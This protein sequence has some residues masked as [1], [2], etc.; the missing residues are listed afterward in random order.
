MAAVF[1]HSVAHR[2][3]LLYFSS[4]FAQVHLYRWR[5]MDYSVDKSASRWV[6]TGRM[7]SG[8]ITPSQ[9]GAR[10]LCFSM[11]SLTGWLTTADPEANFRFVYLLWIS[12]ENNLNL[13]QDSACGGPYRLLI[14]RVVTR[15][16]S[17]NVLHSRIMYLAEL[18]YKKL[19]TNSKK[20]E[21]REMHKYRNRNCLFQLPGRTDTTS[22]S[23]ARKPFPSHKILVRGE[24][25]KVI[26]SASNHNLYV[27]MNKDTT[28]NFAQD[29]PMWKGW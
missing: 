16:V 26:F 10:R 24:E 23:I 4:S 9:I 5:I 3:V 22:K 17:R 20:S 14:T 18:V 15:S 8:A 11:T 12:C 19:C 25:S 29:F 2:P 13:K 27:W 7:G 1:R 21:L 6:K 28:C